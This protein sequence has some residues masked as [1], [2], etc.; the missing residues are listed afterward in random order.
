VSTTRL[1]SVRWDLFCRVIDN[2]GDAGVC[3]R[4]AANLRDLGQTVRLWIDDARPLA[5]MAPGQPGVTVVD[6]TEPAPDLEPAE[7]VVEAFGCDPPARYRERM[8]ER[9]AAQDV[10]P[11]WINLEYLSAEAYVERSHGLPSPVLL[12]PGAGL[13]KRF[14]YPGFTPATGGLLRERG[15]LA[16]RDAFEPRPWLAGLGIPPDGRRVVLFAYPNAPV[17]ALLQALAG[18][19]QRG[20]PSRVLIPPG[21]LVGRATEAWQAL[22]A[23]AGITLHELPWLS[24]PDFDHLLWSGDL[25]CVRGEDSLVRALWAGRPWLWQAYPQ[26]DGAHGPKMEALLARLGALTTP[27]LTTTPRTVDVAGLWRA[28]NG[29]AAPEGLLEAWPAGREAWS[30]WGSDALSWSE[31]LAAGPDLASGLL[32]FALDIRGE[33]RW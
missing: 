24:Q 12:G 9:M 31:R 15:L 18:D 17:A 22:G 10:P 21:P 29:L 16:R 11:A 25:N 20:Q 32:E 4:L 2:Y 6:W 13:R 8:G 27:M 1:K 30:A 3:W 23:P 7:V 14:Y 5:F 26:D 33:G 28:W 19:T